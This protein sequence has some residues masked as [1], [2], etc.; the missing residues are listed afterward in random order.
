MLDRWMMLRMMVVP[1]WDAPDGG[2]ISRLWCSLGYTRYRSDNREDRIKTASWPH[3][4]DT[5]ATEQKSGGWCGLNIKWSARTFFRRFTSFS[6]TMNRWYFHYLS[7]DYCRDKSKGEANIFHSMRY[8][9]D[10][11]F[12]LIKYLINQFYLILWVNLSWFKEISDK[13]A[14]FDY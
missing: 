10:I 12:Y 2:A 8:L 11:Q 3:R 6:R 7:V 1:L 5:D 13:K 14:S 9:K 4:V